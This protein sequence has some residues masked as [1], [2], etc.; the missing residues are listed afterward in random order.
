MADVAKVSEEEAEFTFGP[1]SLA[2]QALRLHGLGALLVAITR[3]ASGC[4]LSTLQARVELPGF[5]VDAVDTTG[6]GDAF[7]AALLAEV[8]EN[9]LLGLGDGERLAAVGRRAN[10]AGAL[11]CTGKG[12]I[13]SMPT[14][15]ALEQ[16]LAAKPLTR[17]V[18]GR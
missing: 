7:V 6:A 15:A 4:Y 18:I 10:A 1:G 3:G 8:V 14:A 5:A 12:G 17:P 16:F 9:G 2:E 13:P 11:T